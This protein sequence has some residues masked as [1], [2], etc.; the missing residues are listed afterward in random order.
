ME[1]IAPFPPQAESQLLQQI[2][3]KL[4]F[5][6]QEEQVEALELISIRIKNSFDP[7]SHQFVMWVNT[8]CLKL[9]DLIVNQNT[10]NT[11]RNQIVER[12]FKVHASEISQCLLNQEEFLDRIA[13]QFNTNDPQQRISSLRIIQHCP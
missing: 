8:I 1:V 6:A 4:Q 2:E 12:I 7:S 11:L 13:H 10:K 5:E 9:A 3:S